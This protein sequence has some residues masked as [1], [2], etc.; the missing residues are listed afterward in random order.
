MKLIKAVDGHYDP[1]ARAA[2]VWLKKPRKNIVAKTV[3][4][5]NAWVNIDYDSKGRMVGIEIIL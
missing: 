5:P 1:A 3:P 4:K 2:Y